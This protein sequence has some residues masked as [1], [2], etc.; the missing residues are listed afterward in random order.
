MPR[1]LFHVQKNTQNLYPASVDLPDLASARIE[2]VRVMGE[3]LKF[4][5]EDL[6]KDEDWQVEV[7]DDHGLILFTVFSSAVDSAAATVIRV[8]DSAAEGRCSGLLN[9]RPADG[10]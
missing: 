6:L 10:G 2:A 1:F 7:A 4:H 5:P 3:Q 8:A 9:E